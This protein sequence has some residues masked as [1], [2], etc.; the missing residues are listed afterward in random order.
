[1]QNRYWIYRRK[2]GTF[3]LQNKITQKQESLKTKDTITA[4]RILANRNQAAEQPSLNRTL[5]KAYLSAKSPELAT[6]TWANVMDHYC[7]SGVESTRER[8]LR[9][10]SSTPFQRLLKVALIDTE[11]DHLFAVLDHRKAGNSAHHYLRRIHNYAL[12]L[13]WLLSPVMA[14]AAW[15]VI[16]SQKKVGLTADEHRRIIEREKNPE[17]RLYYEMLWETGGA[18]SDIANLHW[19]RIDL[20]NRTLCFF[21]QKLERTGGGES[22]LCIGTRI[23]AILD[24]LPQTGYLFPGIGKQPAKNRAGYFRK[25]CISCKIKGKSLHS[26]RYGW[27]Q[28]ARAAG[29]PERDAMNHLGHQSRAI[30]AAYGRNARVSTLPLEYYEERQET[31]ILE[32]RGDTN[33]K[34]ENR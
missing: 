2:N 32:F 23:Q 10:F 19:D 27:A 24:Q 20:V 11:A 1:M 18:Q 4:D 31:K 14:D 33:L 12:H 6:R 3:Y 29:M 30:H 17:R 28:R 8:K 22:C 9:A 34:Q 21:R 13:G 15:P 26:Y 5:A 7:K 16:R 25:V